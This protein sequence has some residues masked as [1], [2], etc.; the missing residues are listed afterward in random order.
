VDGLTDIHAH[1]L[2]GIDDGPPDIEGALAMAR[3]TVQAGTGT[4]VATPHL[5]TDFPDVHL[6]ELA[7]RCRSLCQEIEAQ[8]IALRLVCG[9]EVSLVWALEASREELVLASVGQRGTDLLIE[10]PMTTVGGIDQHLFH[11]RANGFRVTLA[12]PERSAEFQNDEELVADLVNQGVLMQV[13]AKS[14]IDSGH[15]SASG[16]FARNLCA[17]GLAHVLASD[18]HRA[19]EWRPV[20]SLRQGVEAAAALIGPERAAWMA[21]HAPSAVVAGTELP[22]AP[23][24]ASGPRRRRLFGRR[25]R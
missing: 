6:H 16:R 10:T 11:L 2:P 14:L 23:P 25:T 20:T 19:T 7:E 21:R 3:A 13:N 18:G 9:A 1:I 8:G 4:L 12:H 15:R 5:R 22:E 24:V 17:D